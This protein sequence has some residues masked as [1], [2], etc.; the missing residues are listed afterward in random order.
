MSRQVA[1]AGIG[2]SLIPDFRR[3]GNQ[4]LPAKIAAKSEERALDLGVCVA[5]SSAWLPSR[6][7][8]T[9]ARR[10]QNGILA[11]LR[12]GGGGLPLRAELTA[13]GIM[14]P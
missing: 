11:S 4:G 6:R 14:G 1:A 3:I 8:F 7:A 9:R 5:P 12:K 13:S 10:G 2:E